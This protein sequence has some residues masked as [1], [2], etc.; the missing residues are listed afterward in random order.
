M[1]RMRLRDAGQ[2]LLVF[3]AYVVGG[4]LGLQLATV[5]QSAT[6]VWPPTGIAIAACLVLGLRVWPAIL[7]GAFAVNITTTGDV[8]SS[9]GI[10]GGNTLEGVIGALLIERFAN[11]RYAFLNVA[12]VLRFAAIAFLAPIVSASVGVSSLVL[13]GV[14][15]PS[16]A[17]P[18]WLTWWLGD[19]GGALVV[20]PLIVLWATRVP[21]LRRLASTGELLVLGVAVA[22][23]ALIV[24]TPWSAL[25]AANAP[26]G[27]LVFPVLVWPVVRFGPRVA[28][29]VTATISIVAVV[30]STQ[31]A[32]PWVRADPGSSLLLLGAFLAIASLTSLMVGAAVV[33]RQQIEDSLR[34]TE[35]RLRQAEERKVAARDDFL[36]VAAHE[37]RTPLTSLQL[38]TQYILR[39][40]AAERPLPAKALR[41]AAEALSSQTQ[42]LALLIGQ[43][44]DTVRIQTNRMD[45]Q[46]RE[47]DL[48]ELARR[49]ARETQ[50]LTTRHQ[51]EVSA[52][53]RVTATVDAIRIEQVL[54]NLL[55]NAI[56]YSPSGKVAVDVTAED[57]A[58]VRLSV[59][60]HG[61]GIPVGARDR[62][63]DRFF[64]ARKED[65]DGGGLGLGLHVSRHIVELHGGSIAADFPADGG[66]RII[67]RL[68]K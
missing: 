6:A 33:E 21:E 9:I 18:I 32:G 57:G 62:I 47:E 60:D 30:G 19:V 40:L 24:F 14:A 54:R 61:P 58:T 36:S 34:Q 11:G 48:S 13:T 44:L 37:L 55:D 25:A 66:T 15:Q 63:F 29:T 39:E 51:I 20:A 4:K 46:V 42:R 49:V 3:A 28:A 64:Q 68:P 10:A 41:T 45:L 16:A 38:A 67:V 12:T 65:R 22:A 31:G 7:A 1:D 52:P 50:A 56:K 43:L 2:L 27:F 26:I 59:R 23:T 5:H 35:E 17:G 8:A 53:A